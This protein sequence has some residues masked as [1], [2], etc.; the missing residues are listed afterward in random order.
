[1][2]FVI[3]QQRF[4]SHDKDKGRTSPMKK[5]TDNTDSTSSQ[6]QNELLKQM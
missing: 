1:M 2:F 3:Y 5:D 4:H 6:S